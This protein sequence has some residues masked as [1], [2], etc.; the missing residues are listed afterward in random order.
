MYNNLFNNTNIEAISKYENSSVTVCPKQLIPMNKYGL[1]ADT[2]ET[3][4][5]DS[6]F[7]AQAFDK[8]HDDVL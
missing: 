8:H 4:R 3:A 5:V 7:I 6:R 1:F 2:N